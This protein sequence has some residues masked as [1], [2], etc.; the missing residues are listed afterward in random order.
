M[1]VA[2]RKYCFLDHDEE[3]Y[4]LDT[5]YDIE[6]EDYENLLSCALRYCAYFSLDYPFG[7]APSAELAPYVHEIPNPVRVVYHYNEDTMQILKQLSNSIFKFHFHY[8]GKP[9]DP[10]FYRSDYS[11]FFSSVTH[12]GDS[13]LFPRDGEDVSILLQNEHWKEIDY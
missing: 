9:E 1:I 6:G 10:I 12:E 11:V 3:R 4:W 13:F 8:E 7:M 2:M 5:E